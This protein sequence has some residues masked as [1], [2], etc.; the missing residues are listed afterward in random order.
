MEHYQLN[1]P[2]QWNTI[3]SIALNNNFNLTFIMNNNFDIPKTDVISYWI[4]SHVLD[5]HKGFVTLKD[6]R[7]PDDGFD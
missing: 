4:L 2:Q 6:L 5:R 3:C 1:S 7:L